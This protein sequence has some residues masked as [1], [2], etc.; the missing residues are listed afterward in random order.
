MSQKKDVILGHSGDNDGIEEYDNALPDWWLGL[1]AF[2]VVWGI[3]YGVDYHFISKRS[4][5]AGYDAE[6]AA[7]AER[8]PQQQPG[9]LAFDDA[10]VAAG[11]EVFA[12]TC[13]S[14]HNAALTGGIGPNLVDKTW[15]H[16]F[17][18]EQIR[19]VITEGVPAKGMPTWGPL[20][21]PDKVAKVTA[22]V[23]ESA[24][25]A[26]AL[27]GATVAAAGTPTAPATPPGDGAVT[28]AAP[29]SGEDVYKQNC[30]PCHGD[31]L[32]GLVGP[33]L[34]DAQWIHGSSLEQIEATI[35]N[36]VPEKGMVSW[37]PIL[38]AEKIK[39]VASFI[40]GKSNPQ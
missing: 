30:V 21:G 8:W 38:G 36:G 19:K 37:G 24:K 10:T 17:E 20:L 22:F 18:P 23:Y 13:A 4:Q 31:Q 39:A 26:G 27:D 15:I 9:E 1:F 25:K 7:A 29:A 11:A 34:V 5:T 2:T 16:G 3:G 32:Q 14:C 12:T 40:H 35:T 28:A 33:S 6:M